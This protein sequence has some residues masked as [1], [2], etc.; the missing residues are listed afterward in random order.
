MPIIA[1]LALL[2]AMNVLVLDM[3]PLSRLVLLTRPGRTVRRPHSCLYQ[4]ESSKKGTNTE[5]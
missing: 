3:V 1:A 4:L 5:S 2:A